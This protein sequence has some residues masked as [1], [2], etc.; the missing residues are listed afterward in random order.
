MN[1]KRITIQ[2]LYPNMTEEQLERA[3]YSLQRYAE[4]VWRVQQRLKHD[5]ANA[6]NGTIKS[7]LTEPRG[8]S[9]IPGERS[10][11]IN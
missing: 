11:S 6:A 8:S 9:T 3:A 4:I 5:R 2:D 1:G 10:I 7:D